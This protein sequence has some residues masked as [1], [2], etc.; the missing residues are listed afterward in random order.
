[1]L[2]ARSVNW[3]HAARCVPP[4]WALAAALLCFCAV[5]SPS[6]ANYSGGNGT[7]DDPYLISTPQDLLALAADPN[8]WGRHFRLVADV[9]MADVPGDALCI[10]GD[11]VFPFKG[12]FDGAGNRILHYTCI[13]PGGE[14][15]GLFGHLRGLEAEVHDLRMVDPNVDA[16][17]GTSAGG[18][19]G[20]LGTGC[21]VTRCHVEGARVSSNIAAGGL[22]GWSYGIITGCTAQG[23]VTGNYSVG[24]LVGVCGTDAQ[25][26]DCR[27]D[28]RVTASTRVGGLVGSCSLTTIDWSSSSG[29]AAGLS[30]VGG[31]AAVS[32]GG[33]I[34]NCYSTTSVTADATVA[35][36]I[37]HCDMSCNCS[38][39]VLPSI[40]R[41]S[42]CT[43]L[44][45]GKVEI[46]GLIAV[47]EPDCIVEDCFWDTQT[48]GMKTSAEGAGLPTALL[49][50]QRTFADAW[51]DFTPKAGSGDYWVI[52]HE[53]A[54]PLPAWQIPP[55]DPNTAAPPE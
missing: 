14:R 24:G 8:D 34:S 41:N 27:A 37:A 6:L 1:M 19:V 17:T 51:W 49:Q 31:L 47:S 35:G 43:G 46:G 11:H 4:R 30:V 13:C 33:I 55:D 25:I 45:S 44:V 28:A 52:S 48:S 26:R 29:S 50:V 39:G 12:T 32:E 7:H 22:V 9:N 23:E 42:Y 53:P 40:I 15:V 54:Y 18:L 3:N 10:I 5:T 21:R 38:E 16:G 2:Y 36:L 20:H